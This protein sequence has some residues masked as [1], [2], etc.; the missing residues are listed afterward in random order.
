METSLRVFCG[1]HMSDEEQF[2]ISDKY[3]LITCALQLV[4]FPLAL[5]GTKVYNAIQARKIA[6]TILESVA[7]KAK[8]SMAEGNEPTCLVD[9]WVKEM[10]DARAGRGDGD[11]EERRALAREFSD[12]EIAMVV[13]SFLF[14]SQDAMTSALVNTL[15]V[16]PFFFVWL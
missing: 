7:A 13:L 2:A 12:H 11:Q 5:P 3:W 9:A 6:M 4:N 8:L 16:Y 15:S 1:E 14:A 10:I